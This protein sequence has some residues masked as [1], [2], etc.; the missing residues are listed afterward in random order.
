[1]ISPGRLRDR[2]YEVIG[3]PMQLQVAAMGRCYGRNP[4]HPTQEHAE[5]IGFAHVGMDDIDFVSMN[6]TSNPAQLIGGPTVHIGRD[7]AEFQLCG[8]A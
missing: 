8:C 4:S 5:E 6:E 3:H 7:S 1:M 2:N